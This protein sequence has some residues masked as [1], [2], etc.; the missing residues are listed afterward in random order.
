MA[1]I[2]LVA[3]TRK[4]TGRKVKTLRAMGKIPANIYGKDV[5]SHSIEINEKEF[6]E[7]FKKVGETAIVEIAL[8]KE[9]RPVLVHNVQLHPATSEILHVDFLQVNLKEKV[10]AQIPVELVGESP[11]EKSGIG[12]AVLLVQEL[13][14]EALPA[15]LPEKFEIDATNLAEVDQ[16]VKVSELKYDKQK[17]EVKADLESIVAK[18]EPP[19][20]E[21]EVV[22]PAPVEGEEGATEGETPVEGGEQSI[23]G[24]EAKPEGDSQPQS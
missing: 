15:D 1:K 7:V 19:Q 20:K 23:E 6:R 18:V 9:T 4:L 11:A 8:G 3:E 24:Q 2:N 17:I 10:T 14:V 16:V 12:T 21:E 5:K 22:V 13:E